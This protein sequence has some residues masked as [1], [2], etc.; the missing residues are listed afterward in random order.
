MKWLWRDDWTSGPNPLLSA[1]FVAYRAVVKASFDK[2]GRDGISQANRDLRKQSNMSEE[3]IR[4]SPQIPNRP[5]SS[6]L[7]LSLSLLS[8]ISFSHAHIRLL[9]LSLSLPPF[10]LACSHILSN[11]LSLSHSHPH[12]H[13]LGHECLRSNRSEVCGSNA[14]C[15]TK[16]SRYRSG[17]STGFPRESSFARC[18]CANAFRPTGC[19]TNRNS[20]YGA[21]SP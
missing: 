1:E 20:R 18:G 5:C 21:L 19:R 9:S 10:F 14:W 6:S 11:S 3:A 8:L 4:A 12:T 16:S 13:A 7:S 15:S 2:T 17:Y